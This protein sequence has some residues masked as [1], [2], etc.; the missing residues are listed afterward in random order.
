MLCR[1][2]KVARRECRLG[3][4]RVGEKS[5]IR[6]DLRG[7][8]EGGASVLVLS[9]REQGSALVEGRRARRR[10]HLR[11]LRCRE[12]G[13]G[14]LVAA[15]AKVGKPQHQIGGTS[16]GRRGGDRASILRRRFEIARSQECAGLL[17]RI[18]GRLVRESR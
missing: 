7:K 5:E 13:Q 16:T 9:K 11:A 4:V 2:A 10:R 3:C 18:R 14:L 6:S 17:Q 15:S 1:R 8:I 12:R